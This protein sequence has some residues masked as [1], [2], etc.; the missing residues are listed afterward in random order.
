VITGNPALR[1]LA[2]LK[3]RGGLRRQL[4]KLRTAAGCFYALVGGVLGFGW[5]MTIV[6]GRGFF[7]GEVDSERLTGAELQPWVALGIG[8]F[9]VLSLLSAASVR[10]VYIPKQDIERLFSAPVTRADLVRYRMLVDLGRTLFGAVVLAFLTF[11]RMPSPLYGFFGAIVTISTLGILRQAFSL[12]LGSAS[13][14]LGGLLRNR[15]FSGLRVILGIAVWVLIMAAL[16]GGRFTEPLFGGLEGLSR[17]GELLQG[18]AAR[19]LLLPFRPWAAMMCAETP[20]DFSLWIGVCLSLGLVLYELTA[21]LPID[22]REQSL[23]TSEAIAKRISQ[24][25]RGGL[26]TGGRTSQRTAGWQLPRLFGRGPTGAI[27][28][29]KFISVVRKARGTLLIGVLIVTLVTVGVSYL[30]GLTGLEGLDAGERAAQ[31]G[32]VLAS[33]ALIVLLGITYLGGALRFDFRSDLDRMVQIKAWP[34]SGPRV[35]VGTLMPQV[36]LISGLLGI[37]LLVRLVVLDSLGVEGLAIV[38]GLPF[39]VFFWLAVDNA[40]YLFAPVRMVPGQEGSLHHTGRA[41]VLLSVRILLVSVALGIVGSAG[42]AIFV[43]G[44]EL[45]GLDVAQAAWLSAGVAFGVLLAMDAFLA[46]IGGRMLARFDV[47]RDRG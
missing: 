33:S 4:R 5:L 18:E 2:L 19:A 1:R 25:R 45:A 42:A 43:L 10:G 7:G 44:P 12:L 3:L 22:Y 36:L 24:V 30:F 8:V 34:V 6:V 9:F 23:E 39:L 14:R 32:A 37:A 20:A 40:V 13:S 46:W 31:Q 11:S 47:A 16:M 38:C 29:V 28:W 27:A 35:F 21:R 17:G 26:F 41:I 15:G